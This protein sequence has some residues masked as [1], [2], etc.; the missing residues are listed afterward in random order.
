MMDNAFPKAS[1]Y[2]DARSRGAATSA[3][4]FDAARSEISKGEKSLRSMGERLDKH[5]AARGDDALRGMLRGAVFGHAAAAIA[6]YDALARA[7]G[8]GL[9][10]AARAVALAKR[11]R[12]L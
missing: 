5:V 7:D 3:K 9:E 4:G 11:M 6:S 2:F 1:Q 8:R 12:A 10:D